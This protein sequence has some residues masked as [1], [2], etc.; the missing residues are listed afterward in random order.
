LPLRNQGYIDHHQNSWLNS[1]FYICFSTE[2]VTFLHSV[3]L[4]LSFSRW[5]LNVVFM[6]EVC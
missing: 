4:P 1:P 3:K 6:S 5:N 2:Y